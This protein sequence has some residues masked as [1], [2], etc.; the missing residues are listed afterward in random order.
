MFQDNWLQ[1]TVIPILYIHTLIRQNVHIHLK[2]KY[3]ISVRMFWMLK[4]SMKWHK[5]W[6]AIWYV[7]KLCH[8]KMYETKHEISH[9][10]SLDIMKCY[11]S[12]CIKKM[13]MKKGSERNHLT[14]NITKFWIYKTGYEKIS[15]TK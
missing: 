12:S 10:M 11:E 9:K 5:K 7:K 1:Q 8:D 2:S 14:W 6:H 13:I 4:I 3:C 15:E